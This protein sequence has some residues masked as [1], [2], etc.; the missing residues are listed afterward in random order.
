MYDWI[1]DGRPYY[2]Y[3]K[4]W[5]MDNF[6]KK[7]NYVLDNFKWKYQKI[8][9]IVY[10]IDPTLNKNHTFYEQELEKM[11]KIYD[12]E[13]FLFYWR[14]FFDYI[15][16]ENKWAELEDLLREWKKTLDD[17]PIVDYDED[18]EES[19]E[20]IKNM[21]FWTIRKLI[22]NEEVWEEGIMKVL[23]KNGTTLKKLMDYYR[24]HWNSLQDNKYINLADV[25]KEKTL[26]YYK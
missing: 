9:W 12:A 7:L 1:V 26:L 22:M 20:I 6:E 11:R 24:E 8:V 15:F 5:Q 23:F 2:E 3:K 14:E 21:D 4:R 18:F 16:D 17:F 25:I 10:F 13:L 19:F